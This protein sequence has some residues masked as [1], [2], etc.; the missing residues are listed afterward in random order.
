MTAFWDYGPKSIKGKNSVTGGKN[1][2][3]AQDIYYIKVALF[4]QLCYFEIAQDIYYIQKNPNLCCLE[5]NND[6]WEQNDNL[7]LL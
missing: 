5:L 2:K 3:T 7:G 1:T 6:F 4:L